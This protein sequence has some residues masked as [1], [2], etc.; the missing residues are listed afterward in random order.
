MLQISA[1][2]IGQVI[3]RARELEAK[4]GRWDSPDNSHEA[5]SILEDR[6]AMPPPRS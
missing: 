3:I 4:V 1:A 2:K 6:A 5:D